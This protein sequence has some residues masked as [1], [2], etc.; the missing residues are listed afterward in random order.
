[1]VLRSI[2]V[3]SAGKV[4]GLTYAA[5]GLIVGGFMALFAVA[6][7]TMP[8]PQQ[9]QDPNPMA[10]MA[11]MGVA[12]I[13][14]FPIIYGITGFISGI[15]GAL[16]YNGIAAVVGGIELNFEQSPTSQF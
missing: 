11:G 3:L 2:G 13:I 16:V 6:G 12:A 14:L 7:A 15:I 9:A 8:Q 10:V 5:L 1:M 4:L